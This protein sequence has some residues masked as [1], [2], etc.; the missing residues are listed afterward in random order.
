MSAMMMVQLATWD[1]ALS[2]SQ[3]CRLSP[4]MIANPRL[5][6]SL[7]PFSHPVIC[8]LGL[9]MEES[10]PWREWNMNRFCTVEFVQG[11]NLTQTMP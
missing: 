9:R 10:H 7:Y 3:H 4:R 6:H 1:Y 5:D 11:P 2:A 8:L